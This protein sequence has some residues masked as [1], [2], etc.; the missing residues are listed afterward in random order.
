[1]GKYMPL[2]APVPNG[3]F[4]GIQKP[5]AI[6]EHRPYFPPITTDQMGN[7]RQK[8]L[9]A[10]TGPKAPLAPVGRTAATEHSMP[11]SVPAVTPAPLTPL[12][13]CPLV[14]GFDPAWKEGERVH[15]DMQIIKARMQQAFHTNARRGIAD[16]RK[17]PAGAIVVSKVYMFRGIR[18]TVVN[19]DRTQGRWKCLKADGSCV[20]STAQEL[21]PLPI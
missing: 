6:A 14:I 3:R 1:M 18:I 4:L 7:T 2:P 19:Y 17:V 5:V 15:V 12:A 21:E 8:Q 10:N 11:L 13:P 20:Y 9:A 16:G